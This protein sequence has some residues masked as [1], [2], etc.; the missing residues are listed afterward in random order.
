MTESTASRSLAL[1]LS[2]E[3]RMLQEGAA[4]LD[5]KCL[6]LAS[7][8]LREMQAYRRLRA[9]VTAQ[10]QIACAALGGAL[11]EHGLGGLQVMPAGALELRVAVPR[12]GL[13]GVPLVGDPQLALRALPPPFEPVRDSVA[14][15][16]CTDAWRALVVPL[17]QLAA[18][19]TN[20]MLLYAEYRR[21]V[22]RVR[23]LQNVLLPEAARA[24]REI[25]SALDELEQDEAAMMRRAALSAVR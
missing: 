6:L 17:A 13:L 24:L 21:T 12:R 19:S 20:L 23:A 1:A 10:R 25:E 18:H 3:Q 11:A 15:R 8:M 2:D 5:E 9:Q 22:R 7:T 14:A 16:A 4:F